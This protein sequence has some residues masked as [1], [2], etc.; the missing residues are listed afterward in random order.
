MNGLLGW[1]TLKRL[2]GMVPFCYLVNGF[3]FEGRWKNAQNC[4][5]N[6]MV[7]SFGKSS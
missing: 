2:G 7:P 5:K 6:V 1:G 4:A 3:Y